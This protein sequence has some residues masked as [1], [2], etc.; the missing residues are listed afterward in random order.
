MNY[1][2]DA[3]VILPPRFNRIA[4]IG[5]GQVP[6]VVQT[7]G[8]GFAIGKVWT[9]H[10]FDRNHVEHECATAIVNARLNTLR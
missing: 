5:Q 9:D 2:S 7:L 4:G 1:G 8:P 3:V 6:I 10:T